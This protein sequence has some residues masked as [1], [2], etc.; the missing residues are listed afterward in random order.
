MVICYF[1]QQYFT[2]LTVFFLFLQFIIIL[3]ED[4]LLWHR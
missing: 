3:D 2:S 4:H 1:L